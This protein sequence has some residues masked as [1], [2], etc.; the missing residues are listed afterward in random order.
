[1]FQQEPNNQSKHS[2]INEP[3]HENFIS[4]LHASFIKL[5]KL[6]EISKRYFIRIS[7]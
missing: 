7:L 6:N 4:D 5:N 3:K 2:I 1:M